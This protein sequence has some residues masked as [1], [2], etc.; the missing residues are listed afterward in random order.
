MSE[1]E[2]DEIGRQFAASVGSAFSA[3]RD[4]A[5]AKGLSVVYAED[6]LVYELYPDGRRIPLKQIKGP[7]TVK[8]GGKIKLR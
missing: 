7:V 2:M 3:A 4:E 6:D 8:V 1:A 5:L